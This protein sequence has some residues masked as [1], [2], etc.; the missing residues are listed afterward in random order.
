MKHLI[1][2]LAIILTGCKSHWPND[3]QLIKDVTTELS[4][5]KG[6]YVLHVYDCSNMSFDMALNLRLKGYET[7]IYVYTPAFQGHAVVQIRHNDRLYYSDPARQ[8]A[9]INPPKGKF[10]DSFETVNI[11]AKWRKEFIGHLG[12]KK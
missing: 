1:L 8:W 4:K 6:K 7:K 12:V 3:E 10:I 9:F 11:P 5:Y 2:I